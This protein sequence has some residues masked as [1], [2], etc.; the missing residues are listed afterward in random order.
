MYYHKENY[1]FLLNLQEQAKNLPWA[2]NYSLSTYLLSESRCSL[3]WHNPSLTRRQLSHSSDISASEHLMTEINQR[4]NKRMQ[5][6]K[7]TPITPLLKKPAR[8]RKFPSIFSHEKCNVHITKWIPV[9]HLPNDLCTP[10]HCQASFFTVRQDIVLSHLWIHWSLK[11]E[12]WLN[13]QAQRVEI[14]RPKPTWW[15]VT[16]GVPQ[17]KYRASSV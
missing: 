11:A 8:Q 14:S 17:D 9:R 5:S 10:V 7:G 2:Y 4:N 12:G 15:T 13:C 6:L 16:S 3:K 1:V